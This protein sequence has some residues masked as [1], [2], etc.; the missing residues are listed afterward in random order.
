MFTYLFQKNIN[1]KEGICA[2][3]REYSKMVG[4]LLFLKN[5]LGMDFQK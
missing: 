1:Q 3:Y 2:L 5:I 4:S